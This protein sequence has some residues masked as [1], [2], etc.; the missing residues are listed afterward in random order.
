MRGKSGIRGGSRRG[1]RAVLRARSAGRTAP[2]RTV[3]SPAK[4]NARGIRSPSMTEAEWQA[5]V[6]LAACYRLIAHYDMDDLFATHISARVPGGD[7]HFLL[8]QRGM[9]FSQVTASSLVKVDLSG[10]VIFPKGALINEAG[11]VI[12]SAV[13]GARPDVK[14]VIHTHT[15]AGMAVSAMK[16]GL[17]PLC[18]KSMRFHGRLAYHDFEGKATNL[19]ERSRLVRDLGMHNTMILRN[20]G[21]LTCGAT[22]VQTFKRMH[23][24][25]K[26]CKT[27]LAALATGRP[28]DILSENLLEYTASQFDHDDVPSATR[29]SGWESLLEMLDRIDPSYRE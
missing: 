17:L 7:E 5:R 19:D 18:Q 13:H 24:L 26:S 6:D 9:L 10:K 15:V 4:S 20:H 8:N 28:I 23:A 2:K 22:V 16:E 27:Q 29:P 12:H 11:Y 3:G 21:L 14:C 25:E 1:K